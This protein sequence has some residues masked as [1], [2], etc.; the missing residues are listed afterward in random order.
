MPRNDFE[1]HVRR[2]DAE[3]R[4]NGFSCWDPFVSMLF[5][6]IPAANLLRGI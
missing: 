2:D 1:R 6:H 5:S 3:R 4:A